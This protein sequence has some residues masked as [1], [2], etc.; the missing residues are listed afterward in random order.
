MFFRMG[1][2]MENCDIRKEEF[3]KM[4]TEKGCLEGIDL[5]EI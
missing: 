3:G 5:D 1:I 2:I 4:F